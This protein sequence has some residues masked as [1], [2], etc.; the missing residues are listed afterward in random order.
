[1]ESENY[2]NLQS[3]FKHYLISSLQTPRTNTE[4]KQEQKF[5]DSNVASNVCSNATQKKL[6]DYSPNSHTFFKRGGEKIPQKPLFLHLK[7]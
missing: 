4:A 3:Q 6:C 7:K 5:P 2:Q 1:M